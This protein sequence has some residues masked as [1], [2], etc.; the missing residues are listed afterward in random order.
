MIITYYRPAQRAK[1][2]SMDHSRRA[3]LGKWHENDHLASN[4]LLYAAFSK[5][6]FD[7]SFNEFV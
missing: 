1:L 7:R 4:N 2:Q 3:G 5:R 6:R